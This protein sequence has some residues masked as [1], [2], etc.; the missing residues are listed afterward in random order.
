MADFY[1][2]IEDPPAD[3]KF[4]LIAFFGSPGSGKSTAINFLITGTLT[5]PL[6]NSAQLGEGCTKVPIRCSFI[7]TGKFK[8]YSFHYGQRVFLKE[9]DSVDTE[10]VAKYIENLPLTN[11]EELILEIPLKILPKKHLFLE[12]IQFLDLI[13]MPDINLQ[14]AIELNRKSINRQKVDAV[15]IAGNSNRG[16]CNPDMIR[17]ISLIDVFSNIKDTRPTKLFILC[18]KATPDS[19]D[20]IIKCKKSI[21]KSVIKAFDY[22]YKLEDYDEVNIEEGRLEMKLPVDHKKVDLDEVISRCDA[23]SVIQPLNDASCNELAAII[24]E[25][26]CHKIDDE[27]KN[28]LANILKINTVLTVKLRAKIYSIKLKNK[29]NPAFVLINNYLYKNQEY[30]NLK[31]LS[32]RETD[33]ILDQY[34]HYLFN[35]DLED[36]YKEYNDTY[37]GNDRVTLHLATLKQSIIYAIINQVSA[38]MDGHVNKAKNKIQDIL[39]K[40]FQTTASNN[41]DVETFKIGC[42]IDEDYFIM[43]FETKV[44]EKLE[45]AL[46]KFFEQT[47]E[48]TYKDLQCAFK[49][50]KD[51]LK[52]FIDEE[53]TDLMIDRGN[54]NEKRLKVDNTQNTEKEIAC[55]Q[56]MINEIENINAEISLIFKFKVK[57]HSTKEIETRIPELFSRSGTLKIP[58]EPGNYSLENC[59]GNRWIKSSKRFKNSNLKNL[60]DTG[61]IKSTLSIQFQDLKISDAAGIQIIINRNDRSVVARFDKLE[62]E[63]RIKEYLSSIS[64]DQFLYPIFISSVR[65][66]KK[67]ESENF[68]PNI[69]LKDLCSSSPER[70]KKVIIFLLIEG[71][72]PENRRDFEEDINFYKEL[73]DNEIE[74]VTNDKQNPVITVLLPERN[75]G[76]GRKRKIMMLLAEYFDFKRFYMIDDDIDSFYQFDDFSRDHVKY[77]NQTFNAL[78]FMST[79]LDYS[80]SQVNEKIRIESQQC[81]DWGDDLAMM[82]RTFAKS[83]HETNCYNKLRELIQKENFKE[84]DRIISL[85]S[86]LTK[87]CLINDKELEKIK[88]V[89]N[90]IKEK[91]FNNKLKVIGQIGLW[92]QNMYNQKRTLEDRLRSLGKSTHFVSSIRYQVVLYN[93]EAVKGI[94]PVSDDVLFENPLSEN[95]KAIL[96]LKAKNKELDNTDACKA[97]RLGYKYSDK[98]HILYQLV[99]G[100][101]GF[102][103]FNFS[104]KDKVGPSKVNSD[105]TLDDST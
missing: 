87:S 69:L 51:Y 36:I 52:N 72:L 43:F 61:R 19:K 81:I 95:E 53:I 71:G 55:H 76:I 25:I 26:R 3:K 70:L 29:T 9:F 92:N 30:K 12:N 18:I 66:K 39:D 96:V 78:K 83:E 16:M 44:I 59:Y 6:P 88:Q 68:K 45:K 49:K 57:R 73:R 85:F 90:E 89:E 64:D 100:I 10:G 34:C 28:V 104:F 8:L 7:K 63:S 21:Q 17:Y 27:Y 4:L 84:R 65:R 77:P 24:E 62:V 38:V 93:L 42:S 40:K 74:A 99:S 86:I 5:G 23:L 56:N 31:K 82:R 20:Q 1:K 75:L 14:N 48:T 67:D 50:L 103:V 79:V 22:N 58:D 33:D 98:A 13:G 102:E 47:N 80:V 2:S 32:Y 11:R 94:H 91:L 97:A 46:D 101:S 60:I 41:M 15:C 105:L 54:V 35:I 37:D